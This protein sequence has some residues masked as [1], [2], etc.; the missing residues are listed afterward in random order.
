MSD[1]PEKT[2][3]VLGDFL[4]GIGLEVRP[5]SPEDAFM[6]YLTGGQGY[7]KIHNFR[8]WIRH[9]IFG[10][11]DLVEQGLVP[12]KKVLDRNKGE[13]VFTPATREEY[14]TSRAKYYFQMNNHPWFD[15]DFNKGTGGMSTLGVCD[16]SKVVAMVL[17]HEDIAPLLTAKKDEMPRNI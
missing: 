3:D 14:V 7:R 5:M 1:K 9:E 17:A 8:W 10:W 12:C 11:F 16:L 4:E 13:M 15:P 2:P 6:T